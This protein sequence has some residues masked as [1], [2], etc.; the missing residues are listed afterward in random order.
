MK[1]KLFFLVMLLMPIVAAA[2]NHYKV[3]RITPTKNTFDAE[4]Y[5]NAGLYVR[6]GGDGLSD[7]ISYGSSLNL[8]KYEFKDPTT[9]LDSMYNAGW[10]LVNVYTEID[11]SYPNLGKNENV[12]G[13]KV[14]PYTSA[15]NFIF[16][17]RST[18]QARQQTTRGK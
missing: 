18:Q 3:I 12:L 8:N 13:I 5:K 16:K 10:E 2:Q 4:T 14:K 6:D 7:M 15:I 9:M 17:R 11:A 1:K